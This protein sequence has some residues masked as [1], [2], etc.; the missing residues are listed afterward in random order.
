MDIN[1]Q[2]IEVSLVRADNEH[3]LGNWS[4]QTYSGVVLYHKPTGIQVRCTEH[5]SQW[6]NKS[7]AMEKLLVK[8]EA[9]T[10]GK[11]ILKLL[12]DLKASL[13]N[14]EN[15]TLEEYDILYGDIEEIQRKVFE[16]FNND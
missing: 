7:E 12:A 6:K 14:Y 2:D 15:L 4:M 3:S 1:P 5:K 9:A 11:Y 16:R 10:N 8:V 13:G